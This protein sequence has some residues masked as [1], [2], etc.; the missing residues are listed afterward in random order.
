MVACTAGS[1]MTRKD[2]DNITIGMPASDIVEQHGQPIKVKRLKDGSQSYEYV[3]RLPIND[4]VVEENKYFIIV[5]DG[6]VV[7]K[8][9]NFELP[10]A[11]DEIYD[12]DPNDVPN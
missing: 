2:F 7:A 4:Q 12:P 3:E 9:Y 6:K 8:Y 1:V 5:K 11:Y 10:P